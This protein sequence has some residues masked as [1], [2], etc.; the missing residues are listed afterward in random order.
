MKRI[1]TVLAIVFIIL[2]IMSM[3]DN[4][5]SYV[6]VSLG[7]VCGSVIFGIGTKA[8]YDG[9]HVPFDMKYRVAF[10]ITF[11]FSVIALILSPFML[12][13][14]FSETIY[15]VLLALL[16]P[17]VLIFLWAAITSNKKISAIEKEKANKEAKEAAERQA[18][19]QFYLECVKNGIEDFSSP[20]NRQRGQLLAEKYNL[21][22]DK[23]FEELYKEGQELNNRTNEQARQKKLNEMRQNERK[24]FD[25]LNRYANLQG[26]DKRIAMLSDKANALLE[27][28]GAQKD[29]ANYLMSAGVQK[30]SS[31]ATLGGAASGIAGPA[32]GVAT[33]MD[34]Q[35][36]NAEIRQSN[37]AYLNGALP[38]IMGLSSRA[39]ENIDRANR[40]DREIENFKLKLMSDEPADELMKN[41]TFVGTKVYVSETGAVTVSTKA[42][43]DP[44]FMIFGDVPAVVDGTIC[45]DVYDG[46][47]CCASVNLVLPL[48]GIG[49]NVRLK[50]MSLDGGEPGKEYSVKFSATNLCALEK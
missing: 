37:Q 6:V 34:V 33:A 28:A 24:E 45:A 12:A 14:F 9:Q 8:E 48:Y 26:K 49:Q 3:N 17:G 20:K 15:F 18:K 35:R 44:N 39:E 19:E 36:K 43:L 4:R 7:L 5:Y 11:C 23:T 46:S 2:L 38:G 40:I 16:V 31:W 41:V 29:S 50:G 13:G 22:N 25:K 10:V 42:S 27:K 21:P 47:R 1:S 32:A 30:E